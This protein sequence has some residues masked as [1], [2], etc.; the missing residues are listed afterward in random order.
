[1]HVFGFA[2]LPPDLDPDV[3][4]LIEQR[5]E[6]LGSDAELAT[7]IA[8]EPTDGLESLES[9]LGFSVLADRV[10]GRRFG[11]PGFYPAFET[12]ESHPSCYEMV[13]VLADYGDGVLVF[14][15][16]HDGLDPRLSSLCETYATT[17]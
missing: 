5:I 6:G 10:N 8:L 12:V 1:M 3:R 11:E 9:Q 4:S 13:F 14:I 15:P 2:A 16:K 7:F 17:A